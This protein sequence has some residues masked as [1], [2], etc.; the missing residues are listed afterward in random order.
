MELLDL[1]EAELGVVVEEELAVA[2]GDVGM[3]GG[4]EQLLEVVVGQHV[5]GV[6]PTNKKQTQGCQS[7]CE[8]KC[9]NF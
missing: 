4:F 1:G 8:K 6:L 7:V 2:D 9:E 5:E 3:L